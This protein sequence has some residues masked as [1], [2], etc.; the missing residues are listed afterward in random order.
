MSLIGREIE[1]HI[2]EIKIGKFEKAGFT[3][4]G[5]ILDNLFVQGECVEE[6]NRWWQ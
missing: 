5:N 3:K 2:A 1:N 4:G 6:K